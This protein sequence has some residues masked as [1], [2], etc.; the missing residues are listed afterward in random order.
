MVKVDHVWDQ[1][2]QTRSFYKRDS[3]IVIVRNRGL[4]EPHVWNRLAQ[5]QLKIEREG[6]QDR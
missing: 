2:V 5:T 6:C 3:L 4:L 1:K